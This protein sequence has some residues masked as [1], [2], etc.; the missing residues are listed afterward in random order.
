M[1]HGQQTKT[2][3]LTPPGAIIDNAAVTIAALDTLDWEEFEI[4]VAIGAI[5]IAV[6]AMNLTYSDIDGSYTNVTNGNFAT[7]TQPD[8][9]ASALP[10]ASGATGDN[11]LHRW[12]G[13]AE[14]RYYKPAITGGDG[15]AGAYFV[16]WAVL[17]RGR[18]AP[19]TTAERGLA[20]ELRV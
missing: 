9:S 14:K 10:A 17:H 19:N 18:T 5:D 8:G 3:L 11:T 16:V 20:Q 15:T 1:H 2:V 4:N 13:K 12:S 6:A 7:G